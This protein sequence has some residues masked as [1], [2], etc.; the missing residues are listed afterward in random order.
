MCHSLAYVTK[1][2]KRICE[3]DNPTQHKFLLESWTM[4][5][6]NLVEWWYRVSERQTHGPPPLVHADNNERLQYKRKQGIQFWTDNVH[7]CF[8]LFSPGG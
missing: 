6:Y 5:T 8:T 1:R 3:I 2:A 7:R 4:V